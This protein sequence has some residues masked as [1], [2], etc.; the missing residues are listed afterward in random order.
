MPKVSRDYV[1]KYRLHR[2]SGQARVTID[3]RDFYLGPWKTRASLVEYDRLIAE[4]IAGGRRLPSTDSPADLTI[5]ELIAAYRRYART[6]YVK[7]GKPTKYLGHIKAALK[8]LRKLYARTSVSEFGPKRLKAVRQTFIDDKLTRKYINSHVGRI[9]KMFK[10]AASEELVSGS[11]Y[12]ALATVGGL[13]RGRTTAPDRPPVPPVPDDVVQATLPYLP[14]VVADMVRL[15]RLTGM[16]PSEVCILRPGDVDRS[17]PVWLYYPSE[18]K[19]E[20]HGRTRVVYI[21]PRGQEILKPYL[22]RG[23]DD[24]CFCPRESERLRRAE[25]HAARKTPLSCGNRPGTNRKSRP[26][27]QAGGT[28]NKDSLNRAI[29]R[30][31][32]KANEQREKDKLDLLSHWSANRLRHTAATDIRRQYGLEAAQVLL[33]HAKADVTQVYAEV[34]VQ[35]GAAIAQQIG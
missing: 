7:D 2:P 33:G 16:R 30:A 6:Y 22:L 12:H 26:K 25:L 10:W 4:W 19:T 11:V 31:V 32:V 15:A 18:H 14:P 20:H 17:G 21:G 34:D 24:H 28:Y 9:K 35:K 8:P 5:A 1:P 29:A 13:Q 3:G 27:R 23:D